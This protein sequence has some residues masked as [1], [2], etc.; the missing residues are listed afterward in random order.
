MSQLSDYKEAGRGLIERLRLYTDPVAIKF[1]RDISEI[2]DQA[3][4][5]SANGQKWSLCQ[6]F[7]YAR[8]HRMHV[9]MTS[10][11]NFCVPS[12]VALGWE[13]V[14]REELIES[15]VRQGWHKDR[16]AEEKRFAFLG[17]GI[18]K[19]NF[20]RMAQ[21]KGFVCSPLA[22]TIVAPDSILIYCDGVQITHIVQALTYEYKY[23]V[24]SSFEGFG[25]S[26]DKGAL[27][28]FITGRPQVV[29]PGM[30]DRAFTGTNEY[31]M[32]IG[33]PGDLVF[34]VL[35]NLFKSGGRLNIGQPVRPVLPNNITERI[36]PGFS[37]MYDKIQ[38][39][40]NR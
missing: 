1:I 21:F 14:P 28:P 9:A 34:Y 19:E 33:I 11:D 18:G 13:Y 24:T 2:P 40:K 29:I 25:E 31:E 39:Y 6:A 12:S 4:R 37:F 22:D 23:P 3:L 36:T 7:T 35:D 16:E 38:E 17:E 5:P 20:K 15:Q 26:C 30:G 32:A 27:R 8:R 10:D